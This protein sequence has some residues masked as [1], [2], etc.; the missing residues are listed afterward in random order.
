MASFSELVRGFRSNVREGIPTVLHYDGKSIKLDSS[1]N[2]N[3]FVGLTTRKGYYDICDM[4]INCKNCSLFEN[5]D[6][7]PSCKLNLAKPV[8]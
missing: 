1:P 7:M 2:I 4:K 8:I 3:G 6:F 5:K